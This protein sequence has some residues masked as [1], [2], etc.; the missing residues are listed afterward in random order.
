MSDETLNPEQLPVPSISRRPSNRIALL[1]LMISF[2][3][4]VAFWGIL[5]YWTWKSQSL[6][7]AVG[8]SVA[9]VVVM[10]GVHFI[11]YRLWQRQLV[12]DHGPI[13]SAYW[14]PT[15]TA[16]F[17]QGIVFI[18]ALLM[19]DMGQTMCEAV[20]A[21]GAYWLAFGIIVV[22]R[23]V[24]PTRGDIFLIRYGFLLVFCFAVAALPFVGRAL[25]RW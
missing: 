23:P 20:T 6:Y 19:L 17:Q 2:G 9:F 22:R 15:K 21:I 8:R 10:A 12:Q 3:I 18:L 4:N 14:P 1:A 13:S 25:G 11:G 16:L 24:S 5:I 7:M